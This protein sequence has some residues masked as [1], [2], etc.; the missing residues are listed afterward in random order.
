MLRHSKYQA[1]YQ[2]VVGVWLTL[3]IVGVVVAGMS[4]GRLSH[5]LAAV[6]QWDTV[7]PQLDKIL[8]TMLNSETGVRGFLITGNTNYL[9]P[10]E[11]A[12][13]VYRREFDTLGTMTANNSVMLKAVLSLRARAE[14]LADYNSQAVAA[15]TQN[16]D[17]ARVLIATGKGKMIMDQIRAEISAL[18]RIYYTQKSN[19]EDVLNAQLF[20]AILASLAAGIFGVAAGIIAFWLARLTKKNRKRE[21]DLVNAVLQAERSSREKSAFLANMSHEIRTPMNAILGF[22]ELLQ[23]ELAEAK[24]QKYVQ[25]IRSSAASLLQLI[26]DILDMSKIEAGVLELRPEPT[27]LR[28][29]YDFIQTLFS[30]PALKKGI[31]LERQLAPDLPHSLLMDRVR[32]RQ[33]LVNLVGNAI[34]FTDHGSVQTR[35]S[36]QMPI[37]KG[38]V[39]LLIEVA[40]TGVGIPKDRLDAIFRPFVQAGIHREKEIQGTGLGLSIVK[41]LAELMGGAISVSSVPGQGSVFS[42]RFPNVPVSVRVP[43]SAKITADPKVDFNK[44][45]ATTF[46]VVDDNE[47]NLQYI[48][49][50]FKNSHHRLVFCSSGEEAIVK[51]REIMPEMLLLDLRMDGMD[52]SQ[53]LGEIRKIPGLELVPAIAV[54]GSGEQDG[55]FSGYVRKPFSPRGLFDELAE[56]LPRHGAGESSALEEISLPAAA[57]SGPVADELLL[58]LRQL[59]NDPWPGLCN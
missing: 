56:F 4:W 53:A 32:L 44:L 31:K 9:L 29:V 11:L 1:I 55:S 13:T 12:Q 43:A 8:Q 27:D 26:N 10:Y 36:C 6:R 57:A 15:R 39:E 50:I 54:T 59:L 19:A 17:S 38:R 45:R 47:A 16:F 30:E 33:I 48:D 22:S 42:V 18:D 37:Q 28:E 40:D 58:Q 2:F 14:M 35:I 21:T 3:S 23:G 49:G 20:R 51:A 34:K 24:H 5:S 52:G 46:L 25:S 41:R 7:G